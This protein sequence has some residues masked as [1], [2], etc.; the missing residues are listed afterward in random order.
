MIESDWLRV[1]VSCGHMTG[2]S[3]RASWS[4]CTL[5]PPRCASSVLVCPHTQRKQQHAES[6]EEV[7]QEEH[8]RLQQGPEEAEE[9]VSEEVQPADRGVRLDT[10]R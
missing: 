2:S 7:Q 6:Q 10:P 1:G 8:V 5:P 3:S 4:G 9:E